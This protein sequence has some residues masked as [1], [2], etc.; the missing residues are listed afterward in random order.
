ML[1]IHIIA[2]QET[3]QDTEKLVAAVA[4]GDEIPR[5]IVH[6]ILAS[7]LPAHEKKPARIFE[8]VTTVTSAGFETTASVLRV[9]FFHV[10]NNHKILRRLRMELS[11]VT[12]IADLKALE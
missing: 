12:A 2:V 7:K 4:S 8:D 3:T 11:S 6:E 9:I 5:T 10:F 1:L